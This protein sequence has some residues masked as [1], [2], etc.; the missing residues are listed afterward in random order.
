[1]KDDDKNLDKQTVEQARQRRLVAMHL[2]DIEDNPLDAGEIAM[3]EM[4]ERE[5]WPHEKRRAYILDRARS[6]SLVPAAE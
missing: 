4:F 2:Q 5:G 3:F 6:A 1:M